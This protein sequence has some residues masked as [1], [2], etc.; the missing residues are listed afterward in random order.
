[1]ATYRVTGNV[2]WSFSI[3]VVADSEEQAKAHI[4]ELEYE[5]LEDSFDDEYGVEIVKVELEAK[6]R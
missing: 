5:E 2:I 1:M 3:P 6:E 4:E